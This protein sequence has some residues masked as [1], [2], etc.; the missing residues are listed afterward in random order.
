M[1]LYDALLPCI[2]TCYNLI[3][4]TVY[5]PI[6]Q[7]EQIGGLFSHSVLL[8]GC[9]FYTLPPAAVVLQIFGKPCIDDVKPCKAFVVVGDDVVFAFNLYVSYIAAKN[10]ECGVEL[11]A[12]ICRHVSVGCTMQQ[13]Q[14]GVY[15][16]GIEQR[17]LFDVKIGIVPWKTAILG[18]FAVRVAPIAAAPIAGD[19]ADAS[20][21]DGCG[22]NVGAGLQV[23]SHE[24]AV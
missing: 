22:K 3:T 21:C 6:L 23:F 11:L 8:R 9:S 5:L 15:L 14:G 12:F 17:R 4:L 19:V 20:V 2:G 24:T 18:G 10:F 1:G 13:Q 16:V 7:A